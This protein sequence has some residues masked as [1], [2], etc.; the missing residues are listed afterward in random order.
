MK[1]THSLLVVAI[2]LWFLMP[3]GCGR[4]KPDAVTQQEES[5]PVGSSDPPGKPLIRV[6][7]IGHVDHGKTML[8]AAILAVQHQQGLAGAQ[9][10]EELAKGRTVEGDGVSLTAAQVEYETSTRRYLHVDGSSNE[11]IV[12]SMTSGAGSRDGAIL[13]VS[14]ADGPMP[15]TKEHI[16]S[17]RRAN[18]PAV[19]IFLNKCDLV[20]DEEL[21]ELIEL[22]VRELLSK[23]GFPGDEIPL[24][25]GSA[26]E[27][28]QKPDDPKST[29]CIVELLDAMDAYVPEPQ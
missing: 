1:K 28:Y 14:A 19:V 9:T 2:L 6:G 17:A 21:L 4:A 23:C 5:A 29:A 22:E 26:L 10:Y 18:V 20:E 12:K 25:R 8:T 16:E 15:Q 27:A 11:D 13:V 3:T 24:V 7:T